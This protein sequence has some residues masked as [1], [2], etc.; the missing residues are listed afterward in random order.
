MIVPPPE[1][2][3]M[4]GTPAFSTSSVL[5]ISAGLPEMPSTTD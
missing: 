2:R 4:T 5:S 1:K 3:L